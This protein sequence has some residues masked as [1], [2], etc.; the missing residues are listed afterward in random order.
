MGSTINALMEVLSVSSRDRATLES[1]EL[2]SE[3]LVASASMSTDAAELDTADS[4]IIL[5]LASGMR[6]AKM[7]TKYS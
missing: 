5:G 2:S 4:A 3:E 7:Q 6:T 1:V